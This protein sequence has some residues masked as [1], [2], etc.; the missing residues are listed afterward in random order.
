MILNNSQHSAV[1]LN[2]IKPHQI[3]HTHIYQS[4][5]YAW[6]FSLR[7]MNYYPEKIGKKKCQRNRHISNAKESDNKIFLDP[8]KGFMGFFLA[9]HP[10]SFE[11][12]KVVLCNSTDKQLV[13]R[14]N[15][16]FYYGCYHYLIPRS[17]TKGF[18]SSISF[19]CNFNIFRFFTEWCMWVDFSFTCNPES[20]AAFM[21]RVIWLLWLCFCAH[22]YS[23]FSFLSLPW[24]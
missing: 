12:H 16:N 11:I 13:D 17:H 7:S 14:P 5:K 15:D 10:P 2:P 21:N 6:S 23:V 1:P 22:L 4:P 20:Q 3:A 18:I 8:P 9:H 24:L 19:H